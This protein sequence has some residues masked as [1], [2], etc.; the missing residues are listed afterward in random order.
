MAGTKRPGTNSGEQGGI[1][2]EVT[3]GGKRLP[4]FTTVPENRRMPPTE[5]P[6]DTWKPISRT[7]HGKR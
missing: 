1:Y 7:P 2:Q 6:G 3:P 5:K 4:N